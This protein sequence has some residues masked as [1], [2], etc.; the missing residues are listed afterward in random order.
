MLAGRVREPG[1]GLASMRTT[2]FR[3]W[4]HAQSGYAF[5]VGDKIQAMDASRRQD[6]E[7]GFSAS[8]ACSRLASGLGFRRSHGFSPSTFVAT[9]GGAVCVPALPPGG[10]VLAKGTHVCIR[11]RRLGLRVCDRIGVG[12]AADSRSRCGSGKAGASHDHGQK[13]AMIT[14]KIWV[15][16]CRAF[17]FICDI[18]FVRRG[19]RTRQHLFS[20]CLP[21][22][23]MPTSYFRYFS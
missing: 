9:R 2:D 10:A 21:A 13:L 22:N 17:C 12:P 16:I 19:L 11:I 20:A 6:V 8:G 14:V 23:A 18:P 3:A 7:G 15:R 1:M 4:V 5:F